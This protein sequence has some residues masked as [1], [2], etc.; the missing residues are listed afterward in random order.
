MDEL[1][2]RPR[3]QLSVSGKWARVRAFDVAILEVVGNE[4]TNDE[5]FGRET[6]WKEKLETRVKGLNR[7]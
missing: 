2:R 3:R 5:I 7:N 6:S 4:A 1:C